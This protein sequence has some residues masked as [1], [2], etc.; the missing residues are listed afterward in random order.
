MDFSLENFNKL[1]SLK[2]DLELR[3]YFSSSNVYATI[4]RRQF[5]GE[6]FFL[7]TCMKMRVTAY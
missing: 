1:I 2:C 6:L 7:A 5:S 3:N 4:Y